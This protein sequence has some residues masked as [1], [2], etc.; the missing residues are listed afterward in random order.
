VA[1]DVD[2][3]LKVLAGMLTNP[4]TATAT[5]LVNISTGQHAESKVKAD[6]IYAKEIGLK[7][8]SDY[9]SGNQKKTKVVKLKTFQ[10]L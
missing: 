9:L 5:S 10:L 3:V 6:L 7:A 8:L 1:R 4:F 2:T